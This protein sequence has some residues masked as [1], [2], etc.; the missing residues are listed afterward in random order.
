LI[1]FYIVHDA[2]KYNFPKLFFSPLDVFLLSS[3]FF[4][5]F[6]SSS[7][8]SPS[9]FLSLALFLTFSLFPQ[10]YSPH[11]IR[12]ALYLLCF[13]IS[14]SSYLISFPNTHTNTNTNIPNKYPSHLTNTNNFTH[15]MHSTYC[16]TAC[17]QFCKRR[18][19]QRRF[20]TSPLPN[21]R[22]L[23]QSSTE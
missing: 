13:Y 18:E 21:V 2:T 10:P 17:Q 12:T 4:F 15:S 7:F 20:S 1:V 8:L 14:I 5:F 16:K 9:L 3:S 22:R 6:S 11:H 19:S 23:W